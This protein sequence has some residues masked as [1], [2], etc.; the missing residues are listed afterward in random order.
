MKLLTTIAG[1][2]WAG[3]LSAQANIEEAFRARVQE[4]NVRSIVDSLQYLA[5]ADPLTSNYG[6]LYTD[7]EDFNDPSNKGVLQKA[8]AL[9]RSIYLHNGNDSAFF[10]MHKVSEVAKKMAWPEAYAFYRSQALLML[11]NDFRNQA[12]KAE[13]LKGLALEFNQP[14]YQQAK[15]RALPYVLIWL[16]LMEPNEV[17]GLEAQELFDG[18]FALWPNLPSYQRWVLA[19][20]AL[21]EEELKLAKTL[22][23]EAF[24][25]ATEPALYRF[26]LKEA[27]FSSYLMHSDTV[28]A[29]DSLTALS[30]TFADQKY[31]QSAIDIIDQLYPILRSREDYKRALYLLQA[32]DTY[33]RARAQILREQDSKR[34]KALA[35]ILTLR[36][37]LNAH[38]SNQQRLYRVSSITAMFVILVSTLGIYLV[39]SRR[40]RRKKHRMQHEKI[41]FIEANSM[42]YISDIALITDHL[43]R[44]S[45]PRNSYPYLELE[46]F[47]ALKT[48]VR[49]V[50][51]NQDEL[52]SEGDLHAEIDF[53]NKILSLSQ[54]DLT[55]Y[56]INLAKAIKVSTSDT[57][58][59]ERMETSVAAVRQAKSRLKK[60]LFPQS[61]RRIAEEIKR[62]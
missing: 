25:L 14:E 50:T 59:A 49:T 39:L 7:L 62:L 42:R 46:S 45:S 9:A 48:T 24:Q 5:T 32:K 34:K 20:R 30:K 4:W 55:E 18:E 33:E 19:Q 43:N 28:A 52:R 15:D 37:E 53:E 12:L 60:K 27:Y 8:A 58:L 6:K 40:W 3:F 17:I 44:L 41:D 10:L 51:K 31:Y 21:Q 11:N 47:Q 57:E 26:N 16:Q 35:D 13:L 29:I 38:L 1:L 36:Q 23:D 22:F 56:E 61:N 54:E 2:L